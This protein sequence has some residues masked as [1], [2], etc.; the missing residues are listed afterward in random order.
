[1]VIK[2]IRFLKTFT[3][4]KYT[5][6]INTYILIKLDSDFSMTLKYTFPL[7]TKSVTIAKD[8]AAVSRPG[9]H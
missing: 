5:F 7:G 9:Q 6:V 4:F 8:A 2:S 1:M 3:S